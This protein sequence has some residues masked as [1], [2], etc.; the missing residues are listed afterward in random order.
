MAIDW[1]VYGASTVV[2]SLHKSELNGF[3]RNIV[4]GPNE[5]AVIIRDGE[6]ESTLTGTRSNTSGLW[7]NFKKLWGRSSDLQVIYVDTAPI[8]LT[9]YIGK[10][11]RQES[12][13]EIGKL[14]ESRENAY[15]TIEDRTRARVDKTDLTISALT[16]DGQHISAELSLT[17]HV[18][19][20]DAQLLTTLLRGGTA[21][22]DWDI[23]ALVKDELLAKAFIPVIGQHAGSEIRGNQ[24]LLTQIFQSAE[25]LLA[26]KFE[27]FGLELINMSVNWGLTDEDELVIE[28]GRKEREEKGIEFDHT[29]KIREQERELELDRLR[30]S[31]LI[32][33]RKFNA[34]GDAEEAELILSSE[35]NRENLVDGKRVDQAKITTAVKEL[36]LGITQ[37]ESQLRIDT[38]KSEADARFAIEQRRID[39]KRYEADMRFAIEQRQAIAD[40]DVK[41][42]SEE[43]R[44]RIEDAE[45]QRDMET[46]QAMTAQHMQRKEQKIAAEK[47]KRDSILKDAQDRRVA[48]K[49]E[50]L[51]LQQ[52]LG[53]LDSKDKANVMMDMVKGQ[54]DR[55]LSEQQDSNVPDNKQEIEAAQPSATP[56]EESV[57]NTRTTCKSCSSPIQIGWKVCPSCGTP[58]VE[59]SPTQAGPTCRSCS[60]PID[61]EWKVC[62]SCGTPIQR[63]CRA[64]SK[65]LEEGWNS[66]PF[67][68]LSGTT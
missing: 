39:T 42:R 68:G 63:Q 20:N 8:D 26:D 2:S 1:R 18:L 53:G 47:D 17:L 37:K 59:E 13:T 67:C 9:F 4:V 33:L 7:D 15:K 58:A 16:K 11:S 54:S 55:V 61:T 52:K 60:S 22:A 46:M 66:C 25:S 27:L 3:F 12:G 19:T 41:R 24:V 31:N 32:D 49:D 30:A 38:D 29:R 5:A 28:Q 36:E 14:S 44:Q 34:E 10:S 50:R 57:S 56:I 35:I 43:D 65:Q 40:Q 6:I 21:I 51:D 23:A 64:C 62:P 48:E 45:N